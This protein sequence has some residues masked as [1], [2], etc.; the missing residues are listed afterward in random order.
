VDSA[1]V[2]TLGLPEAPSPPL[3]PDID[4]PVAAWI[5]GDNGAVLIVAFDSVHV[6]DEGDSPYSQYIDFLV[7]TPDGWTST[8][9]LPGSDWP[10]PY[11][12]RLDDTEPRWTG[13]AAGQTLVDGS[14]LWLK[15]GIAPTCATAVV[16]TGDGHGQVCNVEPVSGA[17]LVQVP[18]PDST[19]ALEAV[20]P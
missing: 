2:L 18:S 7:R 13:F 14:V 8:G 10:V 16:A 5:A 3:E 4:V 6:S 11:G 12:E 17:F 19:V 20:A 9:G 1:A 15:S